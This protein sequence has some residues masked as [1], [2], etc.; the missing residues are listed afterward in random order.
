MI[1]PILERLLADI[2]IVSFLN[3]DEAWDYISE[4][5]PDLLITDLFSDNVPG[6]TDTFGMNGFELLQK[7]DDC[8]AAYPILVFSGSLA[9]DGIE[10]K[11]ME[12]A[13][14]YLTVDF[15]EKPATEEEINAA[16]LALL[17]DDTPNQNTKLSFRD[18][19][20]P[21]KRIPNATPPDVLPQSGTGLTNAQQLFINEIITS[22][23]K[24]SPEL[25]RE[26][27]EIRA[28]KTEDELVRIFSRGSKIERPTIEAELLSVTMLAKLAELNPTINAG[29][30]NEERQNKP[31][32]PSSIGFCPKCKSEV[33]EGSTGYFCRRRGCSFKI[34]GVIVGQAL[35]KSQVSKLLTNGRTDLLSDFVYE[36]GERFSACLIL[37]AGGNVTLDF[38]K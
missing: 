2:R 15:L 24:P 19:R 8:L 11:A 17:Q 6:R 34:A 4:H 5:P 14:D 7:L 16:L 28:A 18:N 38:P 3:R 20:N 12:C 36:S 10:D 23:G 26:I 9:M 37:D 30:I 1:K 22:A 29:A 25:Q 33:L 32:N 31:A 13:G 21:D 35:N 27:D